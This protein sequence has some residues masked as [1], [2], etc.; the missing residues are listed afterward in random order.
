MF[1]SR[2]SGPTPSIWACVSPF[3]EAPVATGTKQ[4]VLTAP[5][6]VWNVVARALRFGVGVGT[7]LVGPYAQNKRACTAQPCPSDT[8]VGPDGAN[9]AQGIDNP[10]YPKLEAGGSFWSMSFGVGVDL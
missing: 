8:V 5:W 10:G 2:S 4:G 6:G 3:T 1:A 9:P 7:Q